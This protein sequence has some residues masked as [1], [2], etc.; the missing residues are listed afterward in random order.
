MAL[1]C[2][3]STPHGAAVGHH[4][5]A[6]IEG[7][8][9]DAFLLVIVHSW[10]TAEDCAAHGR[11][12]ATFVWPVPVP[13]ENIL[14]SSGA[15]AQ[16]CEAALIAFDDPANPFKGAASVPSV[17]DLETAKA[18]RWANIKQTR[19]LLDEA[20]IE[21]RGFQLDANQQSR[22]DVMGAVMAMQLTGQVSR[23][24]RCA[25]NAM[26]ELTLSDLVDVGVAIAARRQALIE[27]S[28][29]LYQQLQAAATAEDV[30]AVVWPA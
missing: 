23:L 20:P 7:N 10:P 22:Q 17:T 28:D 2:A 29:A 27:I 14:T 4:E 30:G 11:N 18:A 9:T 24:W 21:L 13:V 3:I 19:S 6:R 5:L 8:L 12:G 15:L 16:R 25:D 1:L 26:R